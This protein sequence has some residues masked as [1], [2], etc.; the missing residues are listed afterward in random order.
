MLNFITNNPE[1]VLEVGCREGLFTEILKKIYNITDSWGIEPDETVNEKAKKNI[2]NVI[3]DYFTKK[4]KLPENYFDLIVFNDVLEHMYDPW[5]IVARAKA[6][7]KENGIVIAS[8]PNIKNKRLLKKLIFNDD[9]EYQESGVLD[10]T[11]IRFFTKTTI[12]KLFTDTGYEILKIENVRRKKQGIKY[13]ILDFLTGGRYATFKTTQYG[14][15]ARLLR[16]K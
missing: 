15:T 2:D 14:I 6:L 10:I 1:T 9:F 3:C 12:L 5:D 13:K 16:C 8:I 11:H 4:T 7:L